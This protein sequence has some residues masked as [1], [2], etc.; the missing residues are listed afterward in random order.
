MRLIY[1][2]K[3]CL[4]FLLVVL[5]NSGCNQDEENITLGSGNI[6]KY[7]K[8]I[9][10]APYRKGYKVEIINP[11]SNK[12]YRYFLTS[13]EDESLQG[14]QSIV[15]PIKGITVL[16]ATHVG[17]LSKIDAIDKIKGFTDIKYVYN[18]ELKNQ[19]QNGTTVTFGD[20]QTISP[21]SIIKSNSKLVIH[22]GMKPD[23]TQEEL[24]QKIN[25]YCI[26]N[27]EWKESHPLGKAEWVKFFGVLFQKESIAN[28]YFTEVENAY[29]KLKNQASKYATK[30]SIFAGNIF[31]DYWYAPAGGSFQAQFYKD[32]SAN[33][34]YSDSEGVG[35]LA[36]TLEEIIARNRNTEIWLDPGQSSMN[37]ILNCHPALSKLKAF[38]TKNLFD[39]SHDMNKYWELSASEPHKVLSDLIQIF[40]V[41]PIDSNQLYFYKKLD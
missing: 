18:A 26:P 2:F 25:I 9:S 35:S 17:M 29:L 1:F 23:F 4:F 16:S 20:E 30:P 6:I 36:L 33:Y 24:L 38:E 5:F 12:K 39:Y 10:I 41:R 8:N 31:G 11:D 13:S 22:S 27:F 14:Y 32:A 34:V 21:E 7:A 15:T 28:H 3:S 19:I 40:H 37:K